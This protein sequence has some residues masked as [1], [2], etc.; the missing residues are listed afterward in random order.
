[1]KTFFSS[2]YLL[3]CALLCSNCLLELI[4]NN[5]FP[6][7]SCASN[8]HINSI[9]RKQM[10]FKWCQPVQWYSLNTMYSHFHQI[11]IL[12]RSSNNF[13]HTMQKWLKWRVKAEQ[14]YFSSH[15]L[16][17]WWWNAVRWLL[18]GYT[19]IHNKWWKCREKNGWAEKWTENEI[20][21]YQNI[22]SQ[23]KEWIEKMYKNP[24]SL[25]HL[26]FYGRFHLFYTTQSLQD[27]GKIYKCYTF[28]AISV[29]ALLH[30]KQ[31]ID[32]RVLYRH[33]EWKRARRAKK[34]EIV[35]Q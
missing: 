21:T 32:R 25:S 14:K 15:L 24:H 23:S 10:E 19:E 33:P 8:Q 7:F 27:C 34:V 12:R 13:P 22:Y 30:S 28:F 6:F 4:Q 31:N 11:I 35:I 2:I 1:M 20:E 9:K 26:H 3:R 16:R 18:L 5:F 29:I 17:W